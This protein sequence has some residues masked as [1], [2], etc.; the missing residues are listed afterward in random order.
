MAIV[1]DQVEHVMHLG[2]LV[3]E[4]ETRLRSGV[5]DVCLVKMRDIVKRLRRDP[6]DQQGYSPKQQVIFA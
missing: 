6:D 5:H 2:K 1:K 3:E 4:A